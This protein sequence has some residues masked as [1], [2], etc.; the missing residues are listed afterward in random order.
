MTKPTPPAFPLSVIQCMK[1]KLCWWDQVNPATVIF[2]EIPCCATC[3]RERIAIC[4]GK[5]H[6]DAG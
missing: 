3:K 6:N 1:A 4:E 2:E 5:V